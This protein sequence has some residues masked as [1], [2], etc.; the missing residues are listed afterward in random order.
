MLFPAEAHADNPPESWQVVKAADRIWHLTTKDGG[1]LD[2]V[3][4]KREAEA[5]KV[6]GPYVS[7]YEKEGKWF[8]GEPVPGWKPYKKAS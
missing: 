2:S 1:V 7:L 5:L 4:T 6:S 3:K 8:A